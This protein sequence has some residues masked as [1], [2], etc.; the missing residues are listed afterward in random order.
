[1]ISNLDLSWSFYQIPIAGVLNHENVFD[2]IK[3][4][5]STA[6]V[7]EDANKK[8]VAQSKLI[9]AMDDKI[10][11]QIAGITEPKLIWEKL[12]RNYASKSMYRKASL[13][14]EYMQETA[15]LKACTEKRALSSSISK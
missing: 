9:L 2:M 4:V 6:A 5:S 10:L 1:M 12:E 3:V 11:S 13:I 15:Q 8:R 7:I 14:I